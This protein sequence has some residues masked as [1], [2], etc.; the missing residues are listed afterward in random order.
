MRAREC[1]PLLF[2]L[3]LW[4][5]CAVEDIPFVT[6]RSVET[7]ADAGDSSLRACSGTAQCPAG[8]S[9]VLSGCDGAP[10]ACRKPPLASECGSQLDP[11]CGCDGVTYFNDCLREA[12]GAG[13]AAPGPCL[14]NSNLCGIAGAEPCPSGLFCGKLFPLAAGPGFF[15]G[16]GCPPQLPGVC[17][18]LP[19]SCDSE[20][21][22]DFWISCAGGAS[23]ACVDTCTAIR[24]G[25]LHI[26]TSSCPP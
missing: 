11:V 6:D 7:N 8:E 20:P 14:R 23:A 18:L 13:A 3:A 21:G 5:G 25:L 2:L 12:N 16:A 17:W 19:E 24:S 10:G 9:C 22:S 1:G 15:A 4:L 26:P